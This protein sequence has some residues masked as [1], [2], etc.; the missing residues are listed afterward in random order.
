MQKSLTPK[1]ILF[2]LIKFDTETTKKLQ[3]IVLWKM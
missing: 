1:N 3:T 2:A